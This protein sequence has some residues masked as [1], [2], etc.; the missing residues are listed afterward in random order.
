[1]LPFVLWN[2]SWYHVITWGGVFG[3]QHAFWCKQYVPVGEIGYHIFYFDNWF[4]GSTQH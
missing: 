3:S 1:M 2:Q 4:C